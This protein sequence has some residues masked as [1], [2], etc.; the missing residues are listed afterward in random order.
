MDRPVDGDGLFAPER[1]V[2]ADFGGAQG[3]DPT[4]H[5]RTVSDISGDGRADIVAFGFHGVWTA[6]ATEGGVLRA[7]AVR[8][9]R[10]RGEPQ[11]GHPHATCAGRPTST[12]ISRGDIVAFGDHGVWT[13]LS[14]G[15]GFFDPHRFV[16]ADFGFF[17]AWE[18]T[19]HV[20]TMADLNNDGRADIVGFGTD[21]VWTA[22]SRGD[23]LFEAHRFVLA[24]FG[25]NQGWRGGQE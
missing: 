1:L 21:G 24:N 10:V 15:D 25:T 20:R 18:S 19:R 5:V 3:W 12:T 23:G 2:V 14:R 9:G 22:L 17:Q 16:L 4:M 13:A 8:A 6:L 7:R 11:V